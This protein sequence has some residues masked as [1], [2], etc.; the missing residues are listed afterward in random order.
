MVQHECVWQPHEGGGALPASAGN[1]IDERGIR[2]G[3]AAGASRASN[4]V[5]PLNKGAAQSARGLSGRPS[6]IRPRQP[7]EGSAFFPPLLR[8]NIY[9]EITPPGGMKLSL[10]FLQS[11]W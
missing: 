10:Q 2:S 1:E 3:S 5:F 9:I 6:Q 11:H 8:G 4:S 7:P